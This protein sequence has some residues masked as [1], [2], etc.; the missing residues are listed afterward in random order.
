MWR[1]EFVRLGKHRGSTR[2]TL[3]AWAFVRGWRLI[4]SVGEWPQHRSRNSVAAVPSHSVVY[5]Q[6]LNLLKICLGRLTV[7]RLV[8]CSATELGSK[9]L[10]TSSSFVLANEPAVLAPGVRSGSGADMEILTD[11]A[12]P[13][14]TIAA[15]SPARSSQKALC[16]PS[17]GENRGSSPLGSAN[18]F[19]DLAMASFALAIF[20]EFL[21]NKRRRTAANNAAALRPRKPPQRPLNP[22]SRPP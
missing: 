15:P 2:V 12:R 21:G 22:P 13:K 3:A 17:H 10:A 14:V 1:P 4:A 7:F 18:D 16:A 19:N 9:M 6:I 8:P 5:W 20:G 11:A